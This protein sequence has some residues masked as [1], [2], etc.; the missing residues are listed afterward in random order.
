MR[1]NAY[2]RFT[3][4]LRE[5]FQSFHQNSFR[6]DGLIL[7]ISLIC[8]F[9]FSCMYLNDFNLDIIIGAGGAV[10]VKKGFCGL[11]KSQM[12]QNSLSEVSLIADTY[13][14]YAVFQI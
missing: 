8:F 5:F 3:S 1:D 12:W 6:V 4:G 14:I 2:N 7:D 9:G 11:L 13:C 10:L